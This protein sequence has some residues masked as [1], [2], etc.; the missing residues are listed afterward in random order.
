LICVISE[1]S[2]VV[3][4]QLSARTH[5]TA[6]SSVSWPP[7]RSAFYADF[8]GFSQ[9]TGDPLRNWSGPGWGTPEPPSSACNSAT[10][11]DSAVT[12]NKNFGIFD[13]RCR[14]R[15]LQTL[16]AILENAAGNL[17]GNAAYAALWNRTFPS[18]GR[19]PDQ[20][21]AFV[22]AEWFRVQDSRDG[23]RAYF[24]PQLEEKDRKRAEIEGWI[25]GVF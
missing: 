22:I 9:R 17:I 3:K 15:C 10:Q 7:Q 23:L 1:A 13:L 20:Q 21:D 19:T 16:R 12:K 8:S 4:Y 2:S 25:L 24:Q 5:R 14:S 6:V 18:A 11:I